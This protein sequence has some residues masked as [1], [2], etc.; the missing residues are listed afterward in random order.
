MK[1]KK[2]KIFIFGIFTIFLFWISYQY[3]VQW[4]D[5]TLNGDFGDESE[6]ILVSKLIAQGQILY[7][8]VYNNHGSFVFF[9]GTLLSLLGDYK[10]YIYRYIIIALQDLALLSLIFTPI[11]KSYYKKLYASYIVAFI[12]VFYLPN[13][14]GH[15]Y[16]YQNIAS[17][18]IFILMFQFVLPRLFGND[19]GLIRILIGYFI[20]ISLA[21]TAIIYIPFVILV[22]IITLRK[23]QFYFDLIGL[24]IGL[25]FNIIYTSIIANWTGY[26]AYHVYL[27]S[28]VL[29]N[30]SSIMNYV[31]NILSALT[32]NFNYFLVL[33]II[34]V[35]IFA[36][37]KYMYRKTDFV[38]LVFAIISFL[39][40][41]NEVIFHMMPFIFLAIILFSTVLIM[42]D[43]EGKTELIVDGSIMVVIVYILLQ[44]FETYHNNFLS[45]EIENRFVFISDRIT[46]E[47]DLVFISTF[48]S[49]LYLL[50]NRNPA[51]FHFI[52]LPIQ[53]EYNKNPY[54]GFYRDVVDDL[55]VTQPKMLY[56]NRWTSIDQEEFQWNVYADDIMDYVQSNYNVIEGGMI[57]IRKDINL[58]D[59]GLNGW[60]GLPLN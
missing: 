59:Y 9:P 12:F 53:A 49:Y 33:L 19:I 55:K 38:V 22:F 46:E 50:S 58:V 13:I 10:I 44:P 17:Y 56:I 29:Y 51:S 48:K 40:R 11:S 20:L 43:I 28:V 3:Q 5:M 37:K 1:N 30:E 41:G 16:I 47:N 23:N 35:S 32:L 8:D 34:L 7:Q 15:T 57:W 2:F 6:T 25:V 4:L 21:F 36:I 26:Y 24:F 31:N 14:Y 39:V 54:N 52:Y 60:T 42:I 45:H 27:N 18:L